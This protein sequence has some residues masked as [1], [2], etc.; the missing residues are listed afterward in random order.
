MFA[1][2]TEAP[3]SGPWGHLGR[4]VEVWACT[5]FPSAPQDTSAALA[6]FPT[7]PPL[8]PPDSSLCSLEPGATAVAW[9]WF[10]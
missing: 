1:W 6:K 9:G 8:S 7:R 3:R 2:W 4:E 5:L 10:L